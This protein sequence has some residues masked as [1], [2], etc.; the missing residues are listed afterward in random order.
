MAGNEKVVVRLNDGGLLKGYLRD[1]SP[2]RPKLSLDETG[3][4]KTLPVK[5]EDVKAV[6][7]VKSF[8]GDHEYRERKSYGA[9]RPKGQRVFVKFSDGE[10]LVGFLEGEV[11]W[12][13]GF[14]LSR[15]RDLNG[16]YL[17]PA[18]EDTNNTRVFVVASSVD[19]VTVVPAQAENT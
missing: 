14:F 3:T 1:F 5:L 16:F 13:K 6:F 2:G 12:K 19:D 17:L 7:F 15:Q 11:P 9:A 4:A 8:E 18:D 10:S